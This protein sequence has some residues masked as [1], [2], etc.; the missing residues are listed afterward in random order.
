[1]GRPTDRPQ[2]A[3]VRD[4]TRSDASYRIEWDVRTAYDFIFSLSGDAGST[5]D[6]PAPDRAWLT[7]TRKSMPA[8]VQELIESLFK[9]ELAIH[10]GVLLVDRPD[11]RTSADA[12]ALVE[13]TSPIE[14]VGAVFAEHGHD[15]ELAGLIRRAIDGD[16]TVLPA[17]SNG[18]F[19]NTGQNCAA[20]SRILESTNRASSVK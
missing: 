15:A 9:G 19:G 17:L 6:L 7:E 12:V 18:A 14:L 8:D 5:D 20:T 10:A 3:M 13:S 2:R 4:L 16:S 1:M 11:A